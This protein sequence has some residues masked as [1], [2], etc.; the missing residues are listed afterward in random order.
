MT[1]INKKKIMAL[2]LAGGLSLIKVPVSAIMTREGDKV[3]ANVKVNFRIN[4]DIEST[5]IGSIKQGELLKRILSCDN[6]WSL[7]EYNGRLGFVKNDFIDECE[8]YDLY[9]SIDFSEERKK[10]II[11]EYTLMRLDPFYEASSIKNIPKNAEV[12]VLAHTSNDWY[13]VNYQD[14]LGFVEGDKL[15]DKPYYCEKTKVV[16]AIKDVNIRKAATTKSERYNI[17]YQGEEMPYVGETKYFYMIDY[18]GEV[19]YVSKDYA[20]MEEKDILPVDYLKLVLLKEDSCLFGDASFNH[21]IGY[22]FKNATAEVLFEEG[23]YYYIRSFDDEGFVPKSCVTTLKG[24]TVVI[25]ISSQKLMVYEDQKRV[26]EANVVTGKNKTPTP[27]G[28]YIVENKAKERF[29]TGQD[30][31]VFVERWVQFSGNYGIHDLKMK[32]NYGG[33]VYKKDGSHGCVRMHI[34]PMEKFYQLV[35]TKTPVIIQN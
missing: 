26:F 1:T 10:L 22:L 21:V 24:M 19:A 12:D 31:Q 18:Y 9:H 6:G 4:N 25:D 7:V 29:L 32:G 35:K 8:D 20:K 14:R 3:K 23:D 33:N 2:L 27:I 30:Y 11:Q 17:L 34:I 13:L 5:R 28:K 16:R 15:I